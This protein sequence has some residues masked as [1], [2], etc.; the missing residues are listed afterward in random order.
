[1]MRNRMRTSIFAFVISLLITPAAFAD[2]YIVRDHT[3]T[4]IGHVNKN[5]ANPLLAP[6]GLKNWYT[7]ATVIDPAFNPKTQVRTGPVYD[8]N[9]RT[10]SWTVRNKTAEELAT[11]KAQAAESALLDPSREAL[12]DLILEVEKRLAALEG[13]TAPT[14]DQVRAKVKE[15]IRARLP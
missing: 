8:V 1:M 15:A 13:K 5:L 3:G 4:A 12:V 14:R 9:A 2:W 6:K 10:I 11:E 7:P